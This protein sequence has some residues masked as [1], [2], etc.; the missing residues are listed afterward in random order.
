MNWKIKLIILI[1]VIPVAVMLWPSFLGGNTDLFMVE[2]QSMLPTILP[3]SVVITQKQ[4]MYEIDDIVAFRLSEGKLG[5]I[6]V[7]R[8]IDNTE[9]G[10]M[11]KGDNNP[12]EDTGF[13]KEDKIIGKVVFSTPYVGYILSLIRNPIVMVVVSVGILFTQYQLKKRKKYVQKP[14]FGTQITPTIKNTANYTKFTQQKGPN[15]MLFFIANALNIMVYIVQQV[16]IANGKNLTGDFI[17]RVIFSNLEAS[18]ASSIG[19]A[20]YFG[21][22]VLMYIYAKRKEETFIVSSR[23]SFSQRRITK[24]SAIKGIQV[25]WLLFVLMELFH[26]ITIVNAL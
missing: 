5:K 24:N 25:V 10:F 26:V 17:T 15:Y 16:A 19:F 20:S 22:F 13:F 1:V 6:V 8:I 9:K 14:R 4:A 21:L 23:E 3:G 2:G 11:I 7:H 18:I 12:K